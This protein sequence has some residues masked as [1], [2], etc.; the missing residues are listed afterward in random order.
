MHK[1][2]QND[3][4]SFSIGKS[5]PLE[6]V[7][8]IDAY[9]SSNP[10]TADETQITE[11]TASLGFLITIQKP[12][13][14]E[15]TTIREK[16]YFIFSL[17]KIIK[18]YTGGKI[19]KLHGFDPQELER[20]VGP[21]PPSDV[22]PTQSP[23]QSHREG[24]RGPSQGPYV[25]GNRPPNN[26]QQSDSSLQNGR[27]IRPLP[28]EEQSSGE[29]LPH[30]RPNPVSLPQARPSEEQV[31]Q[32]A[33]SSESIPQ[34]P[35]S[36]PSSDF[37]RKLRPNHSQSEFRTRESQLSITTARD[38]EDSGN[39]TGQQ[40]LNSHKLAGARSTDS[41]RN[42]LQQQPNKMLTSGGA[43]GQLTPS[44]RASS[45]ERSL[46]PANQSMPERSETNT[47]PTPLRTGAPDNWSSSAVQHRERRSSRT[48]SRL[49]SSHQTSSEVSQERPTLAPPQGLRADLSR[50]S[51][52]LSTRSSRR[53]EVSHLESTMPSEGMSPFGAGS[54]TIPNGE[55]RARNPQITSDI[56]PESPAR[57]DGR[58]KALEP[59]LTTSTEPLNEA[60]DGE[61]HRPGLGPM[62][63]KKS[64]KEMANSMLRAA[65]A[66]N[67]FKP[68]AGGAAE[69]L[70]KSE[71]EATNEHDGVSG[72]FPAP[73]VTKELS[74]EIVE[75]PK[76]GEIPENRTGNQELQIPSPAQ[77]NELPQLQTTRVPVE[78]L[79]STAAAPPAHT[80]SSAEYPP[81]A[82]NLLR[83][84]RRRRRRSDYSSKYA[85]S[86]GINHGLLEGR[87][88]EIDTVLNE[89]GWTD[90]TI[91]RN[92][93]EEL[94]SGLK[95]EIT[96]LEAGTWLGVLENGDD[97]VSAV[98]HMIDKVITEC[99]ELDC[100]LTLYNAELGVSWRNKLS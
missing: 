73:S 85:K 11:R 18:K 4:G 42:R 57:E 75:T 10:S 1:G 52:D 24:S 91:H 90:E 82:P 5:W 98:G 37:V 44:D 23:S 76:P 2:R 28:S 8:A 16:D 39:S 19:P 29:R 97:R 20:I 43:N 49:S 14:W 62:F 22:R 3:S 21:G 66:Y 30:K 92:T 40:P 36:F 26:L 87:T 35:G 32:S 64:N 95:K 99:E 86:L 80:V 46:D 78:F 83:E 72:V 89:L 70:L 41:F 34:I 25:Q 69:K 53:D 67:A 17:I 93:F 84:E 6:E 61:V 88:F 51:S 33:D 94:Q 56:V 55:D 13:Y 47:I 38:G 54:N 7:A 48:A 79:E 74:S 27:E 100:L 65:T 96:R 12:Y 59:P 63:K 58:K 31:L 71:K 45:A 68:R 77:P 9:K 50:K 15:A 60:T 81:A